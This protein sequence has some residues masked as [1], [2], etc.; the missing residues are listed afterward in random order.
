MIFGNVVLV[1]GMYSE[2]IVDAEMF[3]SMTLIKNY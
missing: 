2:F 3:L 1:A